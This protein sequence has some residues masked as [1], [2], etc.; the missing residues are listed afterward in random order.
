MVPVR[1]KNPLYQTLKGKDSLAVEWLYECTLV[2]YECHVTN[3][4]ITEINKI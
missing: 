3:T 4:I 1:Q 2:L